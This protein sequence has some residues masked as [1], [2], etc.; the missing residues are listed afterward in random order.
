MERLRIKDVVDY[1]QILI[2]N[3]AFMFSTLES[4]IVNNLIQNGINEIDA[5]FT[6]LF[7]GK[8]LALLIAPCKVCSSPIGWAPTLLS[9]SKGIILRSKSSPQSEIKSSEK[10]MFFYTLGVCAHF[11]Y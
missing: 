11:N 9:A 1:E 10:S 4:D 3:V 6:N 2:N 5:R 7:V 8:E